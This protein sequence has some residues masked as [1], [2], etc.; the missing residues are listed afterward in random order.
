MIEP[1]KIV[2]FA[3]STCPSCKRTK[4]LLKTHDIDYVLVELDTIDAASREKLLQEVRKYN[5]RETFPTL[6]INGG[7][8]VVIGYR[9]DDLKD[10]LLL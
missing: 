5:P 4:E 8:K 10:A 3:L 7:E 9:E 2:L 6:V 1:R